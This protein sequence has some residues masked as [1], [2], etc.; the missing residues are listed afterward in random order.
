MPERDGGAVHQ[1]AP[2]CRPRL[3]CRASSPC[4]RRCRCLPRRARSTTP[5]APQRVPP[6]SRHCIAAIPATGRASTA[7]TTASPAIGPP[8]LSVGPRTRNCRAGRAAAYGRTQRRAGSTT[9][10]GPHDPHQTLG[11]NGPTVGAIGLGCMSFS[12]AYGGYEGIDP[13]PVIHR[14]IELGCTLLDTAD[15]YG[16][17]EEAVV[18][19]PSPG[20][21]TTSCWPPSSASSRAPAPGGRRV[22]VGD[23]A[24]VRERSSGR[25]G[26]SAPT[27]S[28]STTSTAPTTGAH[29]GDDRRDGRARRRGQ[30][31]APRAVGGL[32]RHDPSRRGGPPDRRPA[33]RMVDLEPRHRGRDRADLRGAGDRARAVQPARA[34]LPDRHA[35]LHRRHGGQRHAPPP[36]A[37]QRRRVRRQPVDGRRRARDRRRPRRHA[38]P[39]RAR[40]AARQGPDVVP[41]PGR[42]GSPTSRRTSPRPRSS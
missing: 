10:G 36:P 39:G 18:A 34:W 5:T 4:V 13:T 33:E 22:V 12:P 26:A 9:R 14:A 2:R 19:R 42:S 37:L 32:G 7:T 30:G 41:I 6:A 8:T 28:T 40:L 17:S 27:T 31:A 29:R 23:P 16:P 21:G 3:R 24:Y 38:R 15:A 25:C 11:S 1:G 20:D 35:H